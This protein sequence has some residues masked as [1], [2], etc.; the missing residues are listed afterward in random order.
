MIE[1]SR[2]SSSSL[3]TDREIASRGSEDSWHRPSQTFASFS[4]FLLISYSLFLQIIHQHIHTNIHFDS[5][6]LPHAVPIVP[7]ALERQ[8]PS[9]ERPDF[10]GRSLISPM[11]STQSSLTSASSPSLTPLPYCYGFTS[12]THPSKPKVTPNTLL[13]SL[14]A[15]SLH[16]FVPSLFQSSKNDC[17][18]C[19]EL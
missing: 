10:S 11:A 1:L 2:E 18:R 4:P 6:L 17:I 5:L 13:L 9:L 3:G 15:P 14:T 8:P 16:L 12:S 19:T 7:R